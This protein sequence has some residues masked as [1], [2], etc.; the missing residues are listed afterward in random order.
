MSRF[1]SCDVSRATDDVGD[2]QWGHIAM[3]RSLS[4]DSAVD[5][6]MRACEH[7]LQAIHLS[8]SAVSNEVDSGSDDNKKQLPPPPSFP[9][10]LLIQIGRTLI[11]MGRYND[12]ISYLSPFIKTPISTGLTAVNGIDYQKSSTLHL[13]IG[14]CYLRQEMFVDA[15]KWINVANILEP[16]SSEIWSYLALICLSVHSSSNTPNSLGN[17]VEQAE[18]CVN[19]AL[20]LGMTSSALIR[21]IANSFMSTDRLVVAEDLLRLSIS[22]SI[23]S[24][25]SSSS[26]VNDVADLWKSRKLL[27][28][29]L[30]TQNRAI[31]ALDEYRNIV[32]NDRVA[33]NERIKAGEACLMILKSLDREEEAKVV[34][35]I[36]DSFE[37]M[38]LG[39][40][41]TFAAVNDN[42]TM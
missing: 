36:V 37:N 25:S 5:S 17:R 31:E 39:D 24:S 6:P 8:H 23:S 7:L 35:R 27:A 32:E 10:E 33:T 19:Q 13:I 21:E 38:N 15:E 34:Q 9:L 40:N 11:Q 42:A 26:S 22:N 28:N 12:A 2:M 29:I 4:L 41:P 3:F 14:I 16:K 20:R 30:S 1:V 18:K